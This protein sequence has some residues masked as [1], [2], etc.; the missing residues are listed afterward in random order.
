[1][2][3]PDPNT[4]TT[5]QPELTDDM[6]RVDLADVLEHLAWRRSKFCAVRLDRGFVTISY[7]F[8][9][10]DDGAFVARGRASDSVNTS[11]QHFRSPY[12]KSKC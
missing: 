3:A 4:D 6:T 12:R 1:M 10:S 5:E 9:G 2:P 11:R 7:G 8:S